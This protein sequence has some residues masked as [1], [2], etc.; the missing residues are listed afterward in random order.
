VA[1]AIAPVLAAF[2]HEPRLVWVTLALTLGFA[3][4][5]A[6]AQHQAILLRSR[7]FCGAG[8]TENLNY[9]IGWVAFPALSRLQN[10]PERL[11]S[12]FLKGYGFFPS[13]VMPITMGSTLF[14]EEI[15]LVF[16]GQSGHEAAGV[17]RLWAPTTVAFALIIPFPGCCWPRAER[18]G[19][20]GLPY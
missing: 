9:T 6:A 13:L 2:F 12:Y 4:S 7:R 3:F 5:G 18:G 8:A 15:I 14:A 19:V 10:V 16:L 1:A 20:S 11:R 17:F